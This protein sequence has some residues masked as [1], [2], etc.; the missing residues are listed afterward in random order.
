M[1]S[2]KFLTKSLFKKLQTLVDENMYWRDFLNSFE[3]WNEFPHGIHLAIF[4]EPYL[5]YVLEGKKT[6]E[7]RFSV[8]RSPP[9]KKVNSGD[10]LLLK[11][12]GGPIVGIC[13]VT[14][15][16]SYELEPKSWK[17][18]KKEFTNALCAQ[19]PDFWK[20]RKY[21]CYATLMK[22]KKPITFEPFEVE[23]RDRRGWVVLRSKDEQQLTLDNLT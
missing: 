8:N 13:Q 19:D 21:A 3:S 22:I 4:V 5:T 10:I 20:D 15:V 7:S 9:Y 23:K 14:N 18:I 12:S 17:L 16:W 6:V 11:L 1:N 2:T